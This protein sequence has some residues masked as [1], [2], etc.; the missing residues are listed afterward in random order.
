[1]SAVVI[2]LIILAWLAIPFGMGMYARKNGLTF[3]SIFLISVFLTPIIGAIAFAVDVNHKRKEDEAKRQRKL[4]EQRSPKWACM[5]CG[6]LNSGAFCSA[7]GEKR[8]AAKKEHEGDSTEKTND[9]SGS[10]E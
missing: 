10:A 2:V 5:K 7:C 1:M 6:T 8:P 3:W 9:P 4:Q